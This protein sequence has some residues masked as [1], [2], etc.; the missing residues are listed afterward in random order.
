MSR[1]TH[2]RGIKRNGIK[3]QV[4]RIVMEQHIGRK[5]KPIEVVH[6]INGDIHDNRIENLQ[7]MTRTEHSRMHMIGREIK[8]ETRAKI[9]K[10]NL[11][12]ERP[13]LWA[14]S[15]K[16]AVNAEKR[17]DDGESWRSIARSYGVGHETV[18][19]AVQRLHKQTD[20]KSA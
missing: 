5:L 15:T 6:H 7:L 17:H 13:Y 12:K 8:A 16:Q 1:T 2:Y 10:A 19:N 20:K 4:H 11:G 14:L 3:H 9:S 18:R